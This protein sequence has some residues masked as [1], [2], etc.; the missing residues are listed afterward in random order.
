MCGMCL[1]ATAEVHGLPCALQAARDYKQDSAHHAAL[2]M[3]LP[4]DQDANATAVA[5]AA[6]A[7]GM[8]KS[9]DAAAAAVQDLTTQQTQ[10]A[11]A[12]QVQAIVMPDQQEAR[13]ASQSQAAGASEDQVQV[14]V[15]PDNLPAQQVQGAVQQAQQGQQQQAGTATAAVSS[16][17]GGIKIQST[18][19]AGLRRS[20]GPADKPDAQDTSSSAATTAT[21]AAATLASSAAA[22]PASSTPVKT[23]MGTL[24]LKGKASSSPAETKKVPAAGSSVN[25]QGSATTSAVSASSAGTGA[26]KKSIGPAGKSPPPTPATPREEV[27]VQLIDDADIPATSTS[28]GPAGSSG[29]AATTATAAAAAAAAAASSSV[30]KGVAP[31]DKRAT[32]AAAGV[33]GSLSV[34]Q[35][36]GSTALISALPV[37]TKQEAP[38]ASATKVAA[39]TAASGAAASKVQKYVPLVVDNASHAAGVAPHQ[40]G[41]HYELPSGPVQL[42]VTAEE[43][44]GVLQL[45][46]VKQTLLFHVFDGESQLRVDMLRNLLVQVGA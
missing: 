13:V 8:N 7:A 12:D 26:V 24:P 28:A 41:P 35:A 29:A 11:T 31:K 30:A 3:R 32:P 23:S 37:K 5:A 38:A 44:P 21:A 42:E 14:L 20:I 43:L 6:G 10:Q 40:T 27:V 39:S 34:A 1:W 15:V 16:T 36:A 33:G 18:R 45:L 4:S 25:K 9:A 22:T 46:T 17:A 19:N 2:P